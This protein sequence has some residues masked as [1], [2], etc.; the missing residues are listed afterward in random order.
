VHLVPFFGDAPITTITPAQIE[1]Y[2]TAKLRAGRA[3]KSIRNDL[4]L[5]FGVLA[6]AEKLGWIA[7]NRA[8]TSSSRGG[9]ARRRR[10]PV[11]RSRGSRRR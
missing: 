6:F 7:G 10:H 3:P 1:R 5:L 9:H 11:P 8:S 2:L 4:G